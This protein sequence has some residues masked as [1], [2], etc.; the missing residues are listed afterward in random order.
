MTN[1]R[2]FVREGLEKKIRTKE[3]FS[4]AD[5]F[6]IV[7]YYQLMKEDM[8]LMPILSKRTDFEDA[9]IELAE[10]L[11]GIIHSMMTEMEK[12][13]INP[14]QGKI[15]LGDV[16][17]YSFIMHDPLL[18]KAIGNVA[19]QVVM[20][21]EKVDRDSAIE[22]VKEALPDLLGDFQE[23]FLP[24]LLHRTLPQIFDKMKMHGI[25]QKDA[26]HTLAPKVATIGY[27][28]VRRHGFKVG[29]QLEIGLHFEQPVV[30]STEPADKNDGPDS[31]FG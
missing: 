21:D 31:M 5:Y 28:T 8:G 10:G 14:M 2:G 18:K 7:L 27:E 20:R 9:P 23:V 29:E 24:N 12:N 15:D 19:I 26:L 4:P 3:M 13:N 6:S 11:D 22:Q 17:I 16:N 1:N 25:E 30:D